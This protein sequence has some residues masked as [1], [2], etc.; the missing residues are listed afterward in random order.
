VTLAAT[1]PVNRK[2]RSVGSRVELFE[3]IRRDHHREGLS[4]R[5][6]ARRNRVHRRTV[7]Q[8][9]AGA[10]PPPR[11]PRTVQAPVLDPVKAWID[12]ML[13]EDLEAPRKQRR[14]ST[15]S[16][17]VC[18]HACQDCLQQVRAEPL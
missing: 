6:L 3:A 7:R 2:G 14:V 18:D 16:P 15:P 12:A 13:R 4:I 5:Q 1:G 8:A 17:V 9:L 11:K 10:V